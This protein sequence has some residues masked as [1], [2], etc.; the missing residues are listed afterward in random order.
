MIFL[1]EFTVPS[2]RCVRFLSEL[3]PWP[4]EALMQSHGVTVVEID[5]GALRT[6]HDMFEKLAATFSFPDY[7]GFN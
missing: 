7:F 1:E 2:W 6:E 3:E 4:D 5:G